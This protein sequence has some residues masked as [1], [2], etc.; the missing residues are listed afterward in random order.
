[1]DAAEVGLFGSVVTVG[2]GLVKV[3]ELTTKAALERREKNKN[4]GNG[5][6]KCS[7]TPCGW[8]PEDRALQGRTLEDIKDVSEK[9]LTA[10]QDIKT[11]LAV[12]AARPQYRYRGES[13]GAAHRD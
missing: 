8:T 3:L 11:A 2:V 13:P 12:A 4:G 1:M 10:L 5:K 6:G 7:A 9:Q